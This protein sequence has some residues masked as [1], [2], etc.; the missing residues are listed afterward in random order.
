MEEEF[1]LAYGADGRSVGQKD[2]G[3][4]GDADEESMR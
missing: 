4:Q 1:E 3:V 2:G